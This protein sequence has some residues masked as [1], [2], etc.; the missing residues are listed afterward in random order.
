MEKGAPGNLLVNPAFHAMLRTA[1]VYPLLGLLMVIYV[2]ACKPAESSTKITAIDSIL[3]ANEDYA[4]YS[5]YLNSFSL[6]KKGSS[7]DKVIITDSTTMRAGDIHP[8]T[9]WN[10]VITHLGDHCKFDKDTIRCRKAKDPEWRQL[11]GKIKH[12]S[13]FQREV[14]IASKI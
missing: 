4:V 5:A 12:P 3:V 7:P 8:E 10:W 11:F 2:S 14:F 9:S 13:L 1:P 6:Y